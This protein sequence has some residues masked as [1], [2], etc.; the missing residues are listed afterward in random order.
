MCYIMTRMDQV[1]YQLRKCEPT[2]SRAGWTLKGEH[3]SQ[4]TFGS[5]ED[6]SHPRGS[7]SAQVS[8]TRRGK[9]IWQSRQKE[10]LLE[11]FAKNPY[12]SFKDRQDLAREM[13]LPDESRIRVWFQNRRS[14]TGE[15]GRSPKQCPVDIGGLVS[16]E[17][18]NEIGPRKQSRR[19]QAE[20]RRRPR[21]RL[22][23][24]QV[25][26]LV[27]AFQKNPFPDY[28]T[29]EDLRQR[30][31]LPQDT[32]QIWFQNRR[33]RHSRGDHVTAQGP[34]MLA[35]LCSDEAPGRPCVRELVAAQDSL[36]PLAAEGG[37]G[38][39]TLGPAT[40]ELTFPSTFPPA[41]AWPITATKEQPYAAAWDACPAQLLLDQLPDEVDFEGHWL[42][43]CHPDDLGEQIES[44][45]ELPLTEEE[46][47]ALR[48]L[49]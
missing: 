19:K 18:P 43:F 38:V 31:D 2:W 14:R 40:E 49:L 13:G 9:T 5:M 4:D 34:D 16:Q 27:Q 44:I 30:T 48:D 23:S 3:S 17:H 37:L 25:R 12:P 47:Q 29:R 11:A 10:V 42:E 41:M 8:R 1:Q 7:S 20:S 46:Y 15:V 39:E 22:S 45:P 33:A 36:L 26:I 21:T 24:A 28:A 32:I 6:H 35:S